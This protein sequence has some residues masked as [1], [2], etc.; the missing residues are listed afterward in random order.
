MP[1]HNG[2]FNALRRESGVLDF[3]TL[4]PP[5]ASR[6][7]ALTYKSWFW[8][9]HKLVRLRGDGSLVSWQATLIKGALSYAIQLSVNSNDVG[10][11]TMF[12]CDLDT[13]NFNS[14]SDLDLDSH[15]Q[16]AALN[17][18]FLLSTFKPRPG[19]QDATTGSIMSPLTN[20][21]VNGSSKMRS[22]LMIIGSRPAFYLA[23]ANLDSVLLEGFMGSGF[24]AG[25]QRTATIES[26]WDDEEPE[27]ADTVIV[28]TSANT[29]EVGIES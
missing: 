17:S 25:G 9:Q 22:K 12:S 27:T 8:L 20:G 23:Q 3:L 7:F 18:A 13:P 26:R 24:T 21:K 6:N 15:P 10:G 11:A 4:K 1:H 16:F 2:A 28:A 29:K 14:N 19:N 5:L